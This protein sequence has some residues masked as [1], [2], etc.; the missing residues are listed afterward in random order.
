[1]SY[2]GDGIVNREQLSTSDIHCL[3]AKIDELRRSQ[4]VPGFELSAEMRRLFESQFVRNPL[5]RVS[6]KQEMLGD[7]DPPFVQPVLG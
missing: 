5:D 3:H 4:F 6:G 2:L 7:F 1:M